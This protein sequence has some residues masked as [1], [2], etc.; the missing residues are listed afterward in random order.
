MNIHAQKPELQALVA[1]AQEQHDTSQAVV[2][3]TET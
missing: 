2:T 1:N 3:N